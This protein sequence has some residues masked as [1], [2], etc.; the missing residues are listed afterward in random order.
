MNKF[1]KKYLENYLGICKSLLMGKAIVIETDTLIALAALD[2]K[3]LYEIK[4]R[5][6]K[7][8]W[9]LLLESLINFP[10]RFLLT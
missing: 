7:K 5:P 4:N 9:L 2:S 8:N 6:L 10:K 1:I 3:V